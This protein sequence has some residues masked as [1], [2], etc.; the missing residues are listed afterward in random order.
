MRTVKGTSVHPLGEVR[1]NEEARWSCLCARS[2][3][4]IGWPSP[5]L[6]ARISVTE[7]GAGEKT[8]RS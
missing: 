1:K 8:A 7:G 3:R 4:G 2:T 5:G 6:M